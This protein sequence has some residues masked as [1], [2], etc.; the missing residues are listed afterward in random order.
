MKQSTF[1]L[2]L[3]LSTFLFACVEDEPAPPELA[4][5]DIPEAST[6]SVEQAVDL[7]WYVI[8]STGAEAGSSRQ[9]QGVYYQARNTSYSGRGVT[10]AYATIMYGQPPIQIT[11]VI[12]TL[13]EDGNNP[14]YAW[15]EI[16][17]NAHNH[18]TDPEL[19]RHFPQCPPGVDVA[20]S[21]FHIHFER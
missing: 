16:L 20:E 1:A 5:V 8:H 3:F 2:F 11:G 14:V 19:P 18:D 10:R 21:W 17:S 15:Q 9:D 12:W 6:T 4:D 13:C 7:G